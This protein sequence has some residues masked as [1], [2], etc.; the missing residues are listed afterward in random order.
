MA[1]L[2]HSC[3]VDAEM[4]GVSLGTVGPVVCIP[5]SVVSD[6]ISATVGV[7]STRVIIFSGI[8]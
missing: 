4:I 5:V 2:W 8:S 1:L 3:A 7:G 6:M